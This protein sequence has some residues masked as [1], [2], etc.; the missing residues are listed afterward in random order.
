MPDTQTGFKFQIRARRSTK[1]L[2]PI[3]IKYRLK[4]NSCPP[5]VSSHP[6]HIYR[7]FENERAKRNEESFD[8][9]VK[10]KLLSIRQVGWLRL[11]DQTILSMGEKT[12]IQSPRFSVTLENV[13]T[14]NQ[15]PSKGEE[16]TT[17]RLNIHT[18]K[19]ADRGCYM[20]QLNT[21]PMLNQLGCVDVLGMLNC[22]VHIPT[23]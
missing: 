23:T 21:N 16:E 15:T 12:V 17:W 7:P 10:R 20:C 9:I 22:M 19:E 5:R 18:L 1:K 13:K 8:Y 4:L 3:Y 14:T 2:T 6:S 11:G